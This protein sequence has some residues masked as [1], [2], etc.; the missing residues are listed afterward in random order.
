[1]AI[2]YLDKNGLI[3]FYQ[4]IAGRINQKLSVVSMTK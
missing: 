3:R 2:S 4:I 1:M